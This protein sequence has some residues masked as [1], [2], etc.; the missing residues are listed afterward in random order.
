MVL[1]MLWVVGGNCLSN[2]HC[3]RYRGTRLVTLNFVFIFLKYITLLL[4]RPLPYPNGLVNLSKLH[5][6]IGKTEVRPRRL[7]PLEPYLRS[8]IAS[9]GHPGAH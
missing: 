6:F 1:Q 4:V 5:F 8:K 9:V 3:D 2:N 7:G